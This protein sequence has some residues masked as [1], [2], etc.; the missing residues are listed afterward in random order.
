MP[1]L[2]FIAGIFFI[3][4][5]SILAVAALRRGKQAS[6]APHTPP[7]STA[8]PPATPPPASTGPVLAEIH[9]LNGP[10]AGTRIEIDKLR[11]SFGREIGAGVD[12]TIQARNISA[13]HCTLT[14]DR[15][16]NT[17][18]AEDQRSSNGT[19]VDGQRLT[20][21][22]PY[23]LRGEVE[24]QLATE[25][26]IHMRFIP[27]Q[28]APSHAAPASNIQRTLAMDDEPPR[29]STPSQ[30]PRAYG[31][32]TGSEVYQGLVRDDE[33]IQKTARGKRADLLRSR[34]TKSQPQNHDAEKTARRP[35]QK[36]QPPPTYD[37][38]EL[39]ITD[40]IE[41]GRPNYDDL[42]DEETRLYDDE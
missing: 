42:A 32:G 5:A 26:P 8:P 40:G 11:W 35:M 19:Y 24:L 29:T 39:T 22:E 20:P 4:L 36:R 23:P 33:S 27:R 9:I 7:P 13:I 41:Q 10:Q 21:Y 3:L 34:G 37:P 14:F 15:S 2:I 17:F 30:K 31:H 28:S 6:A 25:N 18:Y 38:D 1:E 16:N 12:F